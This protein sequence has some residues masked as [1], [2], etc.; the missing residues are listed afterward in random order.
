MEEVNNPDCEIA[1]FKVVCNNIFAETALKNVKRNSLL[2]TLLKVNMNFIE[3][4]Y[5]YLE[6]VENC[7]EVLDWYI[8]N[9]VELIM[10]NLSLAEACNNTQNGA[11]VYMNTLRK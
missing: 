2:I 7:D 5:Y 8:S 10:G 1:H 9:G 3:F 11:N 6:E 4:Y